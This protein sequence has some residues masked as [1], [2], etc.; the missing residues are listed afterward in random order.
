MK[1]LLALVALA[2]APVLVF[3][4]FLTAS[5]DRPLLLAIAAAIT[6]SWLVGAVGYTY[7]LLVARTRA[8]RGAL[9]LGASFGNNG[10]LAGRHGL[11]LLSFL[12]TG[13]LDF[14]KTFQQTVHND[15]R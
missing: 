8:E 12:G 10:F 7:A 14:L 13:P 6:A 4:T 11:F 15:A 5:F 9:A 1:R 3:A 2:V